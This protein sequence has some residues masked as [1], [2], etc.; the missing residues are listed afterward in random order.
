MKRFIDLHPEVEFEVIYKPYYVCPVLHRKSHSAF[1]TIYPSS[2]WTKVLIVSRWIDCDKRQWYVNALGG[3]DQFTAYLARIDAACEPYNV[4][5]NFSGGFGPSRNAHKLVALAHR[6]HG[7][8]VQARVVDRI[9][10]DQFENGV[11]VTDEDALIRIGAEAAGLTAEDV[12]LELG[13]E[14]AA[15][16]IHREVEHAREVGGVE[17]VP[18]VLVL[19]RFKVGGY[20]EEKV[21]EDLFNKIYSEQLM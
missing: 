2:R 19:G 7:A 9:F 3:E 6:R 12:R 16:R 8:Q 5:L 17:A 10:A 13:D 20:Q 1:V 15:T 4:H 14:D 18:C 11:D 21:F